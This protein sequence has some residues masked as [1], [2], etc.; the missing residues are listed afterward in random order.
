MVYT[1][2]RIGVH[3]V[4]IEIIHIFYLEGS[5]WVRNWTE[6]RFDIE[7]YIEYYIVKIVSRKGSAVEKPAENEVGEPEQLGNPRELQQT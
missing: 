2:F 7:S 5:S 6:R 3:N 4:H 1:V